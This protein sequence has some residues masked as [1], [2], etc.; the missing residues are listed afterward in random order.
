MR[1]LVASCGVQ[2]PDQGPNLRPLHGE[3]RVLAT[4]PPGKSQD[5]F[6]NGWMIFCFMY[7]TCSL[8]L[9]LLMDVG[10]FHILLFVN[11]TAVNKW[12]NA[13]FWISVIR[14]EIAELHGSFIF[15]FLCNLHA[16]FQNGC[17]D[18]QFHQQ[19]VRGPFP[20]NPLQHCL[21]LVLLSLWWV[22]GDIVLLICISLMISD[23]KHLFLVYVGHLSLG[24]NTSI[25]V[26]CPFLKSGYLF[27]W[28]WV[29][30]VFCIFGY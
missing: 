4:E 19:C 24:E 5:L 14:S 25:Q 9:C 27:S 17:S 22:W 30:W 8:S 10:Y 6:F 16:L 3:R 1:G 18:L 23:V 11:S 20:L 2:L 29:V 7:T 21:L 28:Y 13:S 26:L 15:N 12:V